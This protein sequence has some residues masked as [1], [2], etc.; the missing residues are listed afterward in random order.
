MV[1]KRLIW[2]K[3]SKNT[4][5]FDAIIIFNIFINNSNECLF[6]C[7]RVI[8]CSYYRLDK[9]IKVLENSLDNI[10]LNDVEPTY[11]LKWYA[12]ITISIK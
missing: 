3:L 12:V 5:E 11:S 2:W 10:L 8:Y 1:L 6:Y 7:T 9:N 4:L